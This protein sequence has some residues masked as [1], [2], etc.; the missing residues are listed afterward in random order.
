MA[1]STEELLTGTVDDY[2]VSLAWSLQQAQQQLSELSAAGP[3]GEFPV[4]YQI[5]EMEFEL[6]M[7]LELRQSTEVGQGAGAKILRG[8]VLSGRSAENSASTAASTIKG[9]F[10]AVPSRGGNP[11][12]VLTVSLSQPGAEG[13]FGLAAAVSSISGE[14]LVDVPVH[15]NIDRDL[16]DRLNGGVPLSSGTALSFGVR[17]TG[18]DGIATCQLTTAADDQVKRVAVIIDAMG[19]TETVVFGGDG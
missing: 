12:P 18:A 16:S 2:L 15:F 9:R 8:S 19:R 13:L 6:K 11:P 10:V 5:P 3:T 17:R 7:S 4:T 1:D 14:A